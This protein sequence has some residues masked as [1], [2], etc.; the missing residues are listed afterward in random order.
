[1]AANGSAEVAV[2]SLLWQ[3]ADMDV[4]ERVEQGQAPRGLDGC[5]IRY[6]RRFIF[7]GRGMLRNCWP[8]QRTFPANPFCKASFC[9]C[10]NSGRQWLG[11]AEAIWVVIV[12]KDLRRGSL[13]FWINWNFDPMLLKNRGHFF[14][15]LNRN[16]V[17]GGLSFFRLNFRIGTVFKHQVHQVCVPIPN[18]K[19]ERG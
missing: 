10:L 18:C 3:N 11:S 7:I 2:I 19:H 16:K 9:A 1:M 8:I 17:H 15:C 13:I 4:L 14:L 6:A 12:S 5:S